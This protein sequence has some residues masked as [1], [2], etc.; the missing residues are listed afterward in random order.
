[1]QPFPLPFPLFSHSPLPSPS[2]E[3][4]PRALSRLRLGDLRERSSSLSESGQTHL[5]LLQG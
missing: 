1:M 2:K 3:V 4:V 5:G